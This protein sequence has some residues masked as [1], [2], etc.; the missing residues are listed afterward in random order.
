MPEGICAG[1]TTA[2][3]LFALAPEWLPAGFLAA[4]TTRREMKACKLMWSVAVPRGSGHQEPS[5]SRPLHF[6]NL[7]SSGIQA[8]KSFARSEASAYTCLL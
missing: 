8:E 1:G 6:F 5:L 7:P 4:V 3:D 2:R